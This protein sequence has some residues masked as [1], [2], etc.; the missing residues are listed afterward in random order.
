MIMQHRNAAEA[1]PNGLVALWWRLTVLLC[2][3][4][5][6]SLLVIGLFWVRWALAP[7]I[8]LAGL[9]GP[10][11]IILCAAWHVRS[12]AW[13][14]GGV[15]MVALVVVGL[16]VFAWWPESAEYRSIDRGIASGLWPFFMLGLQVPVS[17]VG[18]FLAGARH[19]GGK[20]AEPD[21]GSSGGEI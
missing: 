7:I 18:M 11:L 8:L 19:C 15:F 10:Y 3:A 4:A 1:R 21:L 16:S 2:L 17:M 9:N 6:A 13:G 12:D 20:K 14:S 5:M